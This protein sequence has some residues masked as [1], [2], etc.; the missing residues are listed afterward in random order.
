[1]LFFPKSIFDQIQAAHLDQRWDMDLTLE[2]IAIPCKLATK[3]LIHD[4][5]L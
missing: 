5:N 2:N 3:N 1:M 4:V